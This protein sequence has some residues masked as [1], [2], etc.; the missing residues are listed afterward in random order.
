MDQMDSNLGERSTT[1]LHL[2]DNHPS[3]PDTVHSPA[4]LLTNPPIRALPPLQNPLPSRRRADELLALYW[5]LHGTMYRFLDQIEFDALYRRVWE[6]EDLGNDGPGFVCLL[7]VIFSMGCIFDPSIAT[8]ERAKAA[9]GFH[10]RARALI[11]SQLIEQRSILTVQCFLL[12]AFYLQATDDPYQC[13]NFVGL[14]IR[15]AQNLR[16][17]LPATSANVRSDHRREVLRQ[18]WHACVFMDRA[19]SLTFARSTMISPQAAS[20]VPR[21]VAHPDGS[22]CFCFA[23]SELPGPRD[24]TLHFFTEVLRLYEIPSEMSQISNEQTSYKEPREDAGYREYFGPQGA[25][26]AGGLLKIHSKLNSWAQQLPTHLRQD[27][28]LVS[29][30]THRRENFLLWLR[31]RNVRI[32]VFRPVLS[33]FSSRYQDDS[34]P[35]ED[36]LPA[37]LAFQCALSCVRTALDTIVQIDSVTSDEGREDLH[38]ILS[39]WGSIIGYIHAAATVLVAAR[40]QKSIVTAVTA[41]AIEEAWHTIMKILKRFQVFSEGAGRYASALSSLYDKVM[42]LFP[43]HLQYRLLYLNP[44]EGLANEQQPQESWQRQSMPVHSLTSTTSTSVPD[45]GQTVMQNYSTT[46][47]DPAAI[48]SGMMIGNSNLAQNWSCQDAFTDFREPSILTGDYPVS[49]SLF[50][51]LDTQ[52]NLEDMSWLLSLPS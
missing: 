49:M 2:Q 44:S 42:Q 22:T 47:E 28:H 27:S 21:P 38:E 31:Y 5:R 1:P 30:T 34:T 45:Q 32:S 12:I 29:S 46:T 24:A 8:A 50:D 6:G 3:A 20:A 4:L 37:A 16:L 26:A 9:D 18:V 15:I 33:A 51:M 19:A 10:Q 41:T 43:D 14:A 23:A 11:D 36:A 7:N 52:S 39:T 17:D 13:W 35:P 25:K 48:E 40:M